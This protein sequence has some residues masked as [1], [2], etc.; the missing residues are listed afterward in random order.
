MAPC[1]GCPKLIDGDRVTN[2]IKNKENSRSR[3]SV[4]VSDLYI[5]SNLENLF[6][7]IADLNH[8]R[9]DDNILNCKPLSSFKL[10]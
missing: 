6:I 4:W 8:S 1:P 7:R 5:S 3:I 9:A 10:G 2:T